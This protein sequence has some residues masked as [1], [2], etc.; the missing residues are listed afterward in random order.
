T[1]FLKKY[2]YGLISDSDYGILNENDLAVATLN[3]TRLTKFIGPGD[4]SPYPR[5][6]C[7][8]T[9]S[10]K[11]V[12]EKTMYDPDYKEDLGMMTIS[13][14]DKSIKNNYYFRHAYGLEWCF[15]FK[16]DIEDILR[17]EEHFCI[18][19]ELLF[20]EKG[21]YSWF[22]EDLKTKKGCKEWF[23]GTCDYSF[24]AKSYNYKII[25]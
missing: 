11:I 1:E 14:K 8:K 25:K 13:I 9:A 10:I 19:G 6:Q 16:K 2:P 3:V 21:K 22:Y 7:F 24:Y 17:G 12:C 4:P 23:E 20:A 18:L 15:E 5:W